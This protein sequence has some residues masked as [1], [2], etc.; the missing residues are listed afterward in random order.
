[1]FGFC[2][3]IYCNQSKREQR[4]IGWLITFI[5]SAIVVLVSASVAAAALVKSVQTAHTVGHSMS[6]MGIRKRYRGVA[7]TR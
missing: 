2:I 3:I 4:F 7:D 5:I 1:M 6:V